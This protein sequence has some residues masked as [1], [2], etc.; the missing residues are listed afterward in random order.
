MYEVFLDGQYLYY[1]NDKEYAI[2]NA[3]LKD[4]LSCASEFTF[5]IP[6]T[7]PRYNDLHERQSM[8]QILRDSKEIFYGEVREVTE[9]IGKTKSV[10]CVSE[11]AFLFDSIQPQ[12]R[13]QN[14]TPEQFFVGLINIH[15]S[16]VEEKKRFVVGMVTVKDPNNSIYRYTNYEDTL[17]AIRSKL[18]ESLNGYLRTRKVNGV[19]YIDLITLEEYGAWATQ[20]IQFGVN[21]LNYTSKKSASELATVCVPLGARLQEQA[22]EGLDAYTTIESVNDGKNYVINE[23]AYRNFGWVEKV[24]NW[25]DVTV[26]FNLLSKATEWINNNQYKILTLE[27]KAVDLA[28]LEVDMSPY[29][30]GDMVCAIAEPFGIDMYFPLMEK[31]TYINEPASNDIILSYQTKVSYTTQQ[32]NAVQEVEKSIPQ[33]SDLLLRAKQNASEII[34]FASEG[35]VHTIYNEKGKPIALCVMDTD[36]INTAKRIWRWSMG[37]LGYSKNGYNGDFELALTMDG[38]MVA[39]FIQGGTIRTS[40]FDVVGSVTKYAADYSQEDIDKVN[41]ILLG[42]TTAT[43]ED[44]EKYDLNADG[45]IDVLDLAIIGRFV[46]RELESITFDTSIRISAGNEKEVIKLQNVSI[47]ANT[48]RAKNVAGEKV[49]AKMYHAKLEDGT[50][51]QSNVT[52]D[53]FE[54]ADGKIVTVVGGIITNIITPDTEISEE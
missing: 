8:V 20:P 32:N 12:A 21:L 36:D 54:T 49:F 23:Q 42:I 43:N 19:R 33:T 34:K 25:N 24:V 30:V 22:V 48:V 41:N 16:K 53:R 29:F 51:A 1:P 6:C 15:N 3:I 40:N 17:T 4:T 47:G 28:E 10:Y 5:Q 52:R 38:A 2:Y 27:L 35:N 45:I 11:L 14:I 9:N 46:K 39:D 26:P 31:V 44:Y 18:C 13:Y 7:N 50:W 37:G